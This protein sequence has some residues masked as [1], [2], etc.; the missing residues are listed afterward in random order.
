M[1]NETGDT[2]QTQCPDP[3]KVLAEIDE[4]YIADGK[5]KPYTK[6]L[7]SRLVE[8]RLELAGWQARAKLGQS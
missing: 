3:K 2:R 1:E 8:T 5:P 4:E 7:Y 6:W